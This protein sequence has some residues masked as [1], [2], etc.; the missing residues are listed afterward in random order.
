M[1]M[2]IP[3]IFHAGIRIRICVADMSH[4]MAENR[5]SHRNCQ[6]RLGLIVDAL[7]ALAALIRAQRHLNTA[8][9]RGMCRRYLVAVQ[10]ATGLYV[11]SGDCVAVASNDLLH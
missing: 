1:D 7:P 3:C 5:L 6:V 9:L 2:K 10:L 11:I 4:M 8:I